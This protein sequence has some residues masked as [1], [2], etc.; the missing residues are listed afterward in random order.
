MVDFVVHD[1]DEA[2][3]EGKKAGAVECSVNVRAELLLLGGMGGLEDQDTLRDEE[4]AGG[5]EKL[6][7]GRRRGG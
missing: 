3:D 4:D 7:G 5:V 2:A 1:D 6:E